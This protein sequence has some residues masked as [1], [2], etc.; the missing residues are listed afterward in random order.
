MSQGRDSTPATILEARRLAAI[1]Y[2]ERGT[3][4]WETAAALGV[5]RSTVTRWHVAYRQGGA[6]ALRA[7][8]NRGGRPRLT[9][10]QI[11]AITRACQGKTLTLAKIGAAIQA[12]YGVRYGRTQVWKLAH[13]HG[14]PIERRRG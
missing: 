6:D 4:D 13:Q 14:W 9:E 10:A 1:P 2:F 7:K 12:Q 3:D 5:E 8:P 11:Q